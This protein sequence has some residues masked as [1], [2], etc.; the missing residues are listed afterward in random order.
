MT[1]G[2]QAGAR[3]RAGNIRNLQLHLFAVKIAEDRVK[4]AFLHRQVLAEAEVQVEVQRII[5]ALNIVSPRLHPSGT[6]RSRF[7]RKFYLIPQECCLHGI[8]IPVAA[9]ASP[10]ANMS[11]RCHRLR[12]GQDFRPHRGPRLTY[13]RILMPGLHPQHLCSYPKSVLSSRPPMDIV[14]RMPDLN[15]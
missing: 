12:R 8:L 1:E 7:L 4:E 15:L 5:H 2:V 11:L 3:V 9:E 10:M 6:L 13:Y 14:L